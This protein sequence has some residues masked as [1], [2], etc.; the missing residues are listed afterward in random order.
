[1]IHLHIKLI[2]DNDGNIDIVFGNDGGYKEGEVNKLLY[3]KGNGTFEEAED[4]VGGVL[5]TRSIATGDLDNDGNIDIVIANREFPPLQILF[6]NG[7][8]IF[9][10]R[11]YSVGVSLNTQM[12]MLSDVDDNGFLDVILGYKESSNLIVYN[13]GNRD[14]DANNYVPLPGGKLA[15]VGMAVGDIDGDGYTDLFIGNTGT[16]SSVEDNQFLFFSTCPNGGAKIHTASWC[17]RCPRFMGRA[18]YLDS[19]QQSLC[20]EC[21][22]DYEQNADKDVEICSDDPCFSQSRPFGSNEC[23]ICIPGTFFNSTI[24]RSE[25]DTSTWSI[26][27]CIDCAKGT[28]S[29][30]AP[31]AIDTC[32]DCLPGTYQNETG[33]TGCLFC[34]AGFFQTERGQ[35]ECDACALG[36]YC[37]EIDTCGGG[38]TPCP[39]GTYNDLLGQVNENA[40]IPCPPG[41][42]S[43]ETGANSSASCFQCNPGEF[44]NETGQ[45]KCISCEKGSYDTL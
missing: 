30:E 15:T 23:A 44:G 1:M 43:T 29:T 35:S 2:L 21:L 20:K 26:P 7:N 9:D 31:L 16:T 27:R 24:S 8:G 33:K 19:S 45:T 10:V 12:V 3:N 37:D 32:F 42:Y 28:Y 18:N 6:N 13:S 17:F 41:T 22:P 40:C 11:N 5:S 14:I 25:I 38:F 36:G 34:D 4:L 39:P